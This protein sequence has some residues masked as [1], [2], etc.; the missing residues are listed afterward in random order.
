MKNHSKK[1]SFKNVSKVCNQ[2]FRLC[3]V[4]FSSVKILNHLVCM[5]W[6]IKATIC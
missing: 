4:G 1:L 5:N 3:V 2:H 6:L